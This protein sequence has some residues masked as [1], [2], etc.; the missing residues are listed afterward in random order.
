MDSIPST[1]IA[2]LEALLRDVPGGMVKVAGGP[3]GVVLAHLTRDL[4]QT[5]TVA[6]PAS[7]AVAVFLDLASPGTLGTRRADGTLSRPGDG[8]TFVANLIQPATL[9]LGGR[10]NLMVAHLPLASFAPL[11]GSW[12]LTALPVPPG[13]F[14]VPHDAVATHLCRALLNRGAET[15]APDAVF[16]T[17]ILGAFQ[18][19]FLHLYCR[20][21]DAHAR[22]ED[23]VLEPWQLRIAEEA[24]LTQLD[25][26]TSISDIAHSCGVSAVHFSRAFRKATSK[27]PHRWLME[28]RLESARHLLETTQ[29]TVAEISLVC[30]F[31]DQSHLTRAF[32]AAYGD[33]PAAW[34]NRRVQALQG[35]R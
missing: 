32:S 8:A 5:C 27:T 10:I 28:R 4:G 11:S 23:T 6:L 19:H 21:A 15:D 1:P 24:M 3:T 35:A 34:R 18:A 17:N 2:R 12:R 13:P 29:S 20:G 7:A 30:G 22:G 9:E 25:R 33:T 14:E 16:S 26:R 31:A